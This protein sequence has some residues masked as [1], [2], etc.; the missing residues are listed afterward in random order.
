MRTLI[1]DNRIPS[2]EAR[3]LAEDLR[4][5]GLTV[6]FRNADRWEGGVERSVAT[7]YAADADVRA[8]YQEAGVAVKGLPEESDEY[9]LGSRGR[10]WYVLGPDGKVNSTGMTKEEA[11]ELLAEVTDA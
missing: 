5:E 6:T 2:P 8:A 10:W 1:Y 11:K 9:A 7:V 4:A 3:S